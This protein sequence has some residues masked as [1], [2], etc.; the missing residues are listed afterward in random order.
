MVRFRSLFIC[1]ALAFGVLLRP[2][3]ALQQPL[4]ASDPIFIRRHLQMELTC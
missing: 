3:Y 2:F 4:L 1:D